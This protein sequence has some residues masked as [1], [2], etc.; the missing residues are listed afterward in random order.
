MALGGKVA[1]ITGASSGIGWATARLFAKRGAVVAISGR[2]VAALDRLKAQ[3]GA[4]AGEVLVLPGDLTDAD[5]AK[6]VVD[7]T[8]RHFGALHVLVNS[9]GILIGGSTQ[10]T[11]MA[12]YDANMNVNARATFATMSAAIPH[13]KRA[14]MHARFEGGGPENRGGSRP[15]MAI[16]NISSVN[17]LQSFAG[18]MAYCA[19]KAAVDHMTRCAAVDLAPLGIRVNAVNPG[20]VETE[21]QKRGGMSE[22]VYE[23]F[24]KRC[25]ETHPLYNARQLCQPEDVAKTI[26]FVSSEDAGCM[27]G[28][29]VVVDGGRACLG[30]R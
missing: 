7:A 21:L 18:T 27:T 29:C 22:E 16:T 23:G 1:L 5:I 24:L 26:A 6:D 10:D 12:T 11:N 4:E 30:A 15:T 9:A 19:S 28:S 2:D 3:I 14:R 25:T 13:M 17:G 20:I 8:A